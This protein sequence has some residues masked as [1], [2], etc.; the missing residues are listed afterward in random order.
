M[1]KGYFHAYQAK[2]MY[3]FLNGIEAVNRSHRFVLLICLHRSFS[4]YSIWSDW[5]PSQNKLYADRN[6]HQCF[7]NIANCYI[8]QGIQLTNHQKRHICHKLLWITRLLIVYIHWI[9]FSSGTFSSKFYA[10]KQFYAWIYEIHFVADYWLS[11]W[12][13]ITGLA[14]R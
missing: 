6:R 14:I 12:V 2:V 8:T 13:M 1:L 3:N 10:F 5:H 4:S 7:K 9:L 11:Q